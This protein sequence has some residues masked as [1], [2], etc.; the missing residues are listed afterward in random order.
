MS[1]PSDRNAGAGSVV[2]VGEPIVREIHI[3]ATPETVFEFFT[4]AGQLTR[5]LATEAT[6][7]PR[8]GGVCHQEHAREDGSGGSYHMRGEFVEVSPPERVVYTWGFTDP[9]AGVPPGSSVVDV[10]LTPDGDGTRLRVE[11]RDLPAAAIDSHAGGWTGMLERLA[12]AVMTT[13]GER[14]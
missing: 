2:D 1:K 13:A 11:H 8:P 10:T 6:L 9:D 14:P 5:W 12:T 3:R 7:D 4:D